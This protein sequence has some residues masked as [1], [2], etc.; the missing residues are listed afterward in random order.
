VSVRKRM[1]TGI[2]KRAAFTQKTFE[3]EARADYEAERCFRIK[4]LRYRMSSVI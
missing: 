4:T 2:S 1:N 3:S